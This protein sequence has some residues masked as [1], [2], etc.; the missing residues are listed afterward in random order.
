MGAGDRWSLLRTASVLALAMAG[1]TTA[2]PALAADAA[3][4]SMKAGALALIAALGCATALLGVVAVRARRELARTR[5]HAERE[6]ADLSAK[7]ARAEAFNRI[8]DQLVIVWSGPDG[9]PTDVRGALPQVSGVPREGSVLTSFSSWLARDSAATLSEA[10]AAL[11]ARG[12]PFAVAV[13]TRRGDHLEAEGRCAGDSALLRFRDMSAERSEVA[14][15]AERNAAVLRDLEALRALLAELPHPA[16]TVDATGTLSWANLAYAKT[17]EAMGSGGPEFLDAAAR[18]DA[19]ST[20]AAGRTWR[21]LVAFTAGGKRRAFEAVLVPTPRGAAG[22]AIDVSEV[23]SG[24]QEL[25]RLVAAHKRTL[26]NV[27]TPISVYGPD[28]RLDYVNAAWRELWGLDEAFLAERPDQG[29]VLDRLRELRKLPEQA[30]FR[31]WRAQ[32]LAAHLSPEP[33]ETLWHLPDGRT[34]RTYAHPNPQGGLTVIQEDVSRVLA[35]E[36]RKLASDRIQRE[37]LD[38]LSDGVAVFG[39]DGR[40]RLSNPAFARLWRW[41]PGAGVAHVDDI[42]AALSAWREGDPVWAELKRAVTSFENRVPVAARIERRDGAVLH[43][44]TVPLPDGATLF[45]SVDI[46]ASVNVERALEDKAEAL[47]D[48]N[49]ALILADR[50]KDA[51]VQHVSYELRSPLTN[52]IGFAQLLSDPTIGEL[53]DKQREYMGYIMSSSSSLLAIINDILDLATIDAGAMQLDLGAVDARQAMDLAAEGLRDRFAED[54]VTLE[55]DAAPDL[56]SLVADAKRVRQVLYNLLSNAVGFSAPGQRVRLSARPADGGG[57]RF[58]VADEG[59]GIPPADLERIFE[60]FET[61]TTG[62]RH[63]GAG[64]GL[65]LVRSFVELHGGTVEIASEAGRGTTVS[66][67]FPAEPAPN[68]ARQAA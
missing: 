52:I 6:A 19:T 26:D 4:V 11:R 33:Q 23:E 62:S 36:A 47:K 29:A 43:L 1:S 30:D 41:T 56:P 59:R 9:L 60:R 58:T 17:A 24:R 15:L 49:E 55:I 5:S 37:T 12:Q 16:W 2:E 38:A 34:L 64:L 65:S 68:P 32:A 57:V 10:V 25:E 8:E 28:K 35:L 53:N 50:L 3:L 67:T 66:V 61:R 63:R 13:R 7:L 45:T 40:L 39:S 44:A 48:K 20:I 22:I 54:G 18:A 51:F 27:P 31:Q 21:R 42:I 46:T 14:R